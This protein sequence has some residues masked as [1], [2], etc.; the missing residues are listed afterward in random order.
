MC[1]VNGPPVGLFLWQYDSRQGPGARWHSLSLRGGEREE[2][3]HFNSDSVGKKKKKGLKREKKQNKLKAQKLWQVS[4]PRKKVEKRGRFPKCSFKLRDVHQSVQMGTLGG[5]GSGGA[6]LAHQTPL[7]HSTFIRRAVKKAT[8]QSMGRWKEAA[9]HP[10][11]SSLLPPLLFFHCHAKSPGF[12]CH[13]AED[14]GN[15]WDALTGAPLHT[16]PPH[17]GL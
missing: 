11:P 2:G 5:V 14:S 12:G 6:T 8:D 16:S 15:Y 10:H 7:T 1:N 9:D 17:Q 3:R 4:P 13:V